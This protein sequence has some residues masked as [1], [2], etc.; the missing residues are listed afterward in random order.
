MEGLDLQHVNREFDP[1]KRS[2][3]EK[4]AAKYIAAEDMKKENE[5]LILTRK[6]KLFADGIAAGLFFVEE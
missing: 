3:L 4:N 6:G 2:Q 5:K 1:E